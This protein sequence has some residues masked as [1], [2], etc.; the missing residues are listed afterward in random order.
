MN[1]RMLLSYCRDGKEKE[2]KYILR[3]NPDIDILWSDGDLLKYTADYGHADILE[4]LIEHQI[5]RIEF[6]GEDTKEKEELFEK[7]K[8]AEEYCSEIS[9]DLA[10]IFEKYL[11]EDD[12]GASAATDIDG[13]MLAEDAAKLA[14]A[15]LTETETAAS[16]ASAQDFTVPP[17]H[18]GSTTLVF[19]PSRL[20]GSETTHDSVSSRAVSTTYSIQSVKAD[21]ASETFMPANDKALTAACP[22]SAAA[23][24]AADD[25]AQILGEQGAYSEDQ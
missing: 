7:L 24:L 18:G 4:M 20:D 12:E 16:A 19:L 23:G 8:E 2:V 21:S 10:K 1:Y 17:I 22:P 5:R 14:A 6:E 9:D 3:H 11:R 15:K 13:A 25:D